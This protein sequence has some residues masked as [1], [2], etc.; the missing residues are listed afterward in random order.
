M[1]EK[2]TLLTGVSAMEAVDLGEGTALCMADGPCG[3]KTR[4]GN[5]VCF[6]NTGLMAASWDKELCNEIGEM[7]GVEALR[8][9][10]DLMLVPAINIKR[11]PLAGRNF[12]YYSE[13]PFLT[14]TLAAEYING[15]KKKGVLTC[16]KHF[17]CNNQESYRWTQNSIVDDD[18]LRN[19]YLKAFEIVVK[20]TK[21]DCV[22]AAYNLING[23]Y[24]C[25]NKYSIVNDIDQKLRKFVTYLDGRD[26]RVVLAAKL[27]NKATL[28][29]TLM[30]KYSQ[31]MAE[32]MMGMADYI[33]SRLTLLDE[34]QKQAEREKENRRKVS[35][36]RS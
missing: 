6:M 23:V 9:G 8:C 20:N 29:Y 1:Q 32:R 14:G 16:V 24:A 13:D 3:V 12:E 10:V 18:T 21:V 17:A 35:A 28:L 15:L 2:I 34:I 4:D 36:E 30:E 22:M 33:S 5:A 7:I 11:S 19:I 27:E 25:Q 26:S 31:S